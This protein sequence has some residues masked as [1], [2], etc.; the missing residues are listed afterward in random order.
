M[1]DD[2]AL[3]R[4]ALEVLDRSLRSREAGIEKRASPQGQRIF[5]FRRA[6]ET[7]LAERPARPGL[8]VSAKLSELDRAER[9]L[10]IVDYCRPA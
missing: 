5:D 6:A 9:T 3:A 2:S 1:H 7:L 4:F 10:E 8:D